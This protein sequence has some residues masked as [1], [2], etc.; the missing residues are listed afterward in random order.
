V[1]PVYCHSRF[2]LDCSK[3][4]M[5]YFDWT[6]RK[7][8][9]TVQAMDLKHGVGAEFHIKARFQEEAEAKAMRV[10]EQHHGPLLRRSGGD[11]EL[12]F[13]R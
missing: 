4:T 11:I 7:L 3:R 9:V 10:I 5:K 12:R 6:G 2:R 1:L 8:S 13:I